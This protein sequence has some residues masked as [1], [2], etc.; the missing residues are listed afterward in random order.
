VRPRVWGRTANRARLVNMGVPSTVPPPPSHPGGCLAGIPPMK[1]YPG[2]L[3]RRAGAEGSRGKRPCPHAGAH[4]KR[5]G[6]GQ[7]GRPSPFPLTAT[8]VESLPSSRCAQG[9]P[10]SIAIPLAVTPTRALRLWIPRGQRQWSRPRRWLPQVPGAP[11]RRRVGR[12]RR[13]QPRR[14]ALRR[15][16]RGWAGRRAVWAPPGPRARRRPRRGMAGRRRLHLRR[17]QA[18]PSQVAR[19]WRRPGSRQ[20]AGPARPTAR[21][22]AGSPRRRGVKRLNRCR[23]LAG[24][25]R[26]RG[27]RWTRACRVR[28]RGRLARTRPGV[29]RRRRASRCHP[30]GRALPRRLRRRR[31]RL[32][33]TP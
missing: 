31:A 12:L 15:V 9:A 25:S 29:A 4:K 24:S 14:A 1:S 30:A 21:P 10:F 8:R 20:P 13:Q 6:G 7:T 22:R 27:R 2:G 32:R 23:P 19:P 26:R 3:A 11:R 28:R 5:V 33:M 16:P 17:R 18:P